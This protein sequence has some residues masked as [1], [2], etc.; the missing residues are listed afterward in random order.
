MDVIEQTLA[1]LGG[2]AAV[3]ITVAAAC[4]GLFRVFGERWNGS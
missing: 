4:F 2:L 1:A 3:A